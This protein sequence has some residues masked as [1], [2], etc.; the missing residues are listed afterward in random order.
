MCT[1]PP[2][3]EYRREIGIERKR[4]SF[5]GIRLQIA[6]YSLGFQRDGASLNILL[7]REG[8]AG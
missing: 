4:E 1:V 5:T 7:V 2:P 8:K 6:A 3:T